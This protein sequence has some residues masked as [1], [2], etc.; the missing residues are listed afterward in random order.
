MPTVS[1][2][3][4]FHQN[5]NLKIPLSAIKILRNHFC[6]NSPQ[7]QQTPLSSFFFV[8]FKMSESHMLPPINP[9][10]FQYNGLAPNAR[11][12]SSPDWNNEARTLVGNKPASEWRFRF[13]LGCFYK[14]LS[15]R[16]SW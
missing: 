8:S 14:C 4:T 2:W 15:C 5:H 16:P 10:D 6:S 13:A 7:A 9:R 3:H 11:Q 12:C 1:W